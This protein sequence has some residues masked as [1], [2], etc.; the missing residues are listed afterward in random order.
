MK[1][2]SIMGQLL[3]TATC[4]EE[5]WSIYFLLTSFFSM[6]LYTLGGYRRK[7]R[8][9]PPS[10]GQDS[11]PFFSA[12]RCTDA[13]GAAQCASHKMRSTQHQDRARTAQLAP[14]TGMP[15]A[16]KQTATSN[17]TSPRER[18]IEVLHLSSHTRLMQV[19]PGHPLADPKR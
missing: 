2:H 1:K 5:G 8:A 14:A 13:G 18:T 15:A 4:S 16:A 11:T 19:L 7:V 17:A 9:P 6:K 3:R 12:S 10:G